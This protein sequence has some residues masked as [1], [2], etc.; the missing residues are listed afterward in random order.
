MDVYDIA[1]QLL[2]SWELNS[3]K[4]KAANIN[5]LIHKLL[6]SENGGKTVWDVLDDEQKKALADALPVL[7]WFALNYVAYDLHTNAIDAWMWEIPTFANNISAIVSNHYQEIS[8]AWVRS[9]DKYYENETQAY[10]LDT[11]KVVYDD[12][13]GLYATR[14]NTLT[15]S[16]QDG[17]SIFYSVD[18]G[19]TWKYYDKPVVLEESPESIQCFSIYRGV[20][21]EVKNVSMNGWAGSILGNGNFW[22]LLIGSAFIVG[23][24]VVGIEMSRKKKKEEAEETT[25]E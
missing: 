15:I 24:C 13:V 20:K 3:P 2:I 9:Y 10:M 1:D 4:E 6:D 23:F 18:G 19:N 21:S 17:S 12:P 16:G 14:T 11:S 25:E 7:I 22:F 8:V 5:W